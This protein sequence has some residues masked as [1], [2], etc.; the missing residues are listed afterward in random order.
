VTTRIGIVGVPGAGKTKLAN[1]IKR[2]MPEEKFVVVDGYVEKNQDALQMSV[3]V[4]ATYLPNL[5]IAIEREREIRKLVIEERNFIVCGTIF[6]TLCYTG[7]HAEVIANSPGDEEKKQG[8]LMREMTAAQ[9]FAYLAVDSF[10]NFT[11]LLYLP[12]T[13]PELLVVIPYKND[14]TDLPPEV[15]ALDKT[16]QDALRRYGDP[17]TVLKDKHHQNV[18]TVVDILESERNG[19]KQSPVA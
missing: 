5:H 14:K 9:M 17:A 11:H 12:V 19:T 16:L 10:I 15:Q 18:K 2:A 6:D 13:D 3:G 1:A 7:F 4:E 8:L